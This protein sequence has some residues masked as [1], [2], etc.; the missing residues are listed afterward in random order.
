MSPNDTEGSLWGCGSGHTGQ[1]V[2]KFLASGGG[3]RKGQPLGGGPRGS[4]GPGLYGHPQGLVGTRK[5]P[6]LL[7]GTVHCSVSIKSLKWQLALK[8]IPDQRRLEAT[9]N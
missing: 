6:G 3:R 4:W 9:L 8:L 2:P 1:V 5:A 7:A